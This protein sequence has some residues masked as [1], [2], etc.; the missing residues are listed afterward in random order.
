MTRP[1]FLSLILL[2]AL[3][4]G[5][6]IA[7]ETIV[8]AG[9]G[10]S[11][12]VVS[13]FFR[14][15]DEDSLCGE[16]DFVVPERSIKHAGGIQASDTHLFG[17]TGR[18]LTRTELDGIRAEIFLARIPLTFVI[19]PNLGITEI[20]LDQLK[21][22]LQ[23][24]VTSWK[25][26]GG[27]DVTIKLVGREPTEAVLMALT[28]S[29]PQMAEAHFDLRLTRDHQLLQMMNTEDRQG[30]LSFGAA[31]NFTPE[32]CL[33]VEGLDIGLAMGLVYNKDNSENPLI[34]CVQSFASSE[35]WRKRVGELGFF[36]I[37]QLEDR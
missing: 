27:P 17:R 14:L 37:N 36:P 16:Y 30:V 2:A 35:A 29:I 10:P 5:P 8:I 6:V 32:M 34:K 4:A 15:L 31:S 26:I 9:A 22:I 20:S 23:G 24:K 33:E 18:P 12:V 28:G 7:E 1:R 13:D 25:E 11:T 21:E 3:L 19:D